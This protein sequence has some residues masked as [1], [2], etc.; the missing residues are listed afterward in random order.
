MT[1]GPGT[2]PRTRSEDLRL[3]PH[4]QPQPYDQMLRTWSY[5]WWQPVIGV[6]LVGV[7]FL[8]ASSLVLVMVA[9]VWA[10]FQPG[11]FVQDTAANLEV[12]DTRPATLLGVNLGLAS[13]ILVTAAVMRWVHR[14]RPRWLSSVVP[15]LRWRFLGAC[16]G[17]AVVALMAQ[18]LVST[19][20]PGDVNGVEASLN[21]FT[22]ETAVF[23]IVVLLTTP[24]QAA[25]EEY[26]FRGY[27][28]QAFGS[29]SRSRWVAILGTA[30][31]F[32]I[33]HGSQNFP[34]F[35]DRFAFG[36]LAGWLVVRTGGLEAGIALHVLNNFLAFAFAL[37][38]GDIG[39][40]LTASEASW[41]NIV[42]TLTQSLTYIALVLWVS[43][44]MGL[45]TRT[46]PPVS[47]VTPA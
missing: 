6:L 3:F 32:A 40:A 13:M 4:R 10:A 7:A 27:L 5:R 21:P 14:L 8:L 15:R 11:S 44:R 42:L 46:R 38:L 34:L 17:L 29:L 47:A 43:R 33:A 18:V 41:W 31:L 36:V 12:G 30:T 39:S 20:I 22:T 25:G 16:L 35:F 26:L 19:L 37:A 45:Q 24:L 2:D 9:A 28:L 1:A 23:I